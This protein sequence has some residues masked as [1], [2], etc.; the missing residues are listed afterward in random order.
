MCSFS[1]TCWLSQTSGGGY[2]VCHEQCHFDG[3]HYEQFKSTVMDTSV[4][5]HTA[6]YIVA[7]L[8]AVAE[9]QHAS[10]PR[11]LN[12]FIDD[13]FIIREQDDVQFD[14]ILA[15]AQKHTA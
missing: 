15:A 7:C 2:V 13:G 5:P 10:W 4:A 6:V 12:S 3:Q 9:Q 14:C 1:C 8:K 11:T